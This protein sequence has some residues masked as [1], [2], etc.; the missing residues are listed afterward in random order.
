MVVLGFVVVLEPER[1]GATN[2]GGR[3]AAAA[4]GRAE[5]GAGGSLLFSPS[6]RSG[7]AGIFL[8]PA[9][10]DCRGN[11]CDRNDEA[12]ALATGI[13]GGGI[14]QRRIRF[15]AVN[16]EEEEEEDTAGTAPVLTTEEERPNFV[17]DDGAA[18]LFCLGRG[19]VVVA[20]ASA[21]VREKEDDNDD[22]D[23]NDAGG[24]GGG[25]GGDANQEG[26]GRPG[27]RLS[28]VREFCCELLY[29]Y[30][31]KLCFFTFCVF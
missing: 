26:G 16:V 2:V 8:S 6:D 21:V 3:G 22:N 29:H 13:V 25:G 12:A 18:A 28:I 11:G 14:I 1:A 10:L 23:D 19:A 9:V 24:T 15:D 17:R 30:H 27:G 5:D 4:R 20:V 31:S 7:G